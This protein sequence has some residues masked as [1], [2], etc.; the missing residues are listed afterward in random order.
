MDTTTI[1]ILIIIGS[2]LIIGLL[3]FLLVKGAKKKKGL[4]SVITDYENKYKHIID[5]D[6]EINKRTLEFT[7][8]SDDFQIQ[9]VESK[10]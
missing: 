3:I 10:E 2:F 7:E 1:L 9:I 6:E 4:S 5:V 8:Q